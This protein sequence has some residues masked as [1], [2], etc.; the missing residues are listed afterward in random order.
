MDVEELIQINRLLRAEILRAIELLYPYAFCKKCSGSRKVGRGGQEYK[1]DFGDTHTTP[2]ILEPCPACTDG[3]DSEVFAFISQ[4]AKS[5]L[6]T[7]EHEAVLKQSSFGTMQG[8]AAA[9]EKWEE[10]KSKSGDLFSKETL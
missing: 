7:K 10:A 3:W 6:F 2:Y 1:D 9:K 5:G 8:L 4:H